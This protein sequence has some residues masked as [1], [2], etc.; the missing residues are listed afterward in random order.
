MKVA[1]C[2]NL[3]ILEFKDSLKHVTSPCING[4]NLT[5][6]EFK[7]FSYFSGIYIFS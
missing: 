6:L 5:I 4:F 1:L 2:F 3:T 7:V